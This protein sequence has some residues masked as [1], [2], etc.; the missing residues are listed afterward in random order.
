[1]AA[2]PGRL[3]PRAAP[4][5][6]AAFGLA[7]CVPFVLWLAAAAN[8]HTGV[9][10]GGSPAMAAVRTLVL[11]QVLV[12]AIAVPGCLRRTAWSV[13][14]C[15]ALNV[16]VLAWPLFALLWLAGAATARQVIL[17]EALVSVAVAVLWGLN[18]GCQALPAGASAAATATVQVI[19]LAA[20]WTCRDS[21]MGWVGL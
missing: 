9:L 10:E 19:A 21:W 15:D 18:R 6:G 13:Q 11:V 16:V 4:A 20:A 3:M 8:L 2:D 12:A 7:Y 5:G 14:L 1:M 17:A